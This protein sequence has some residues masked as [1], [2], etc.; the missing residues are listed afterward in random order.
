M[1]FSENLYNLFPCKWERKGN[2][3]IDI[4]LKN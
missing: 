3:D 4:S 1:I 2:E